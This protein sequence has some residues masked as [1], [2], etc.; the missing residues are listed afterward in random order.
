MEAVEVE[1]WGEVCVSEVL[2]LRL[3]L[4]P[5]FLTHTSSGPEAIST[6]STLTFGC[7]SGSAAGMVA[8]LS[9]IITIQEAGVASIGVSLGSGN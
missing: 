1:G 5:I 3:Q 2:V 8:S 7:W 4:R 6:I 9:E